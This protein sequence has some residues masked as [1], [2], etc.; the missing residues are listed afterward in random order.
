MYKVKIGELTYVCSKVGF[1][2]T[3]DKYEFMNATYKCTSLE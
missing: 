2:L 1:S 3:L